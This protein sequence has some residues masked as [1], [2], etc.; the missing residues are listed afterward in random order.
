MFCRSYINYYLANGAVVMPAYGVPGDA[1]VRDAL[2]AIYPDRE[3]VMVDLNAI[4]PG[5]GGIHC[6]TQQQPA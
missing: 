1:A 6:I 5:G 3:V 2:Q 4:A